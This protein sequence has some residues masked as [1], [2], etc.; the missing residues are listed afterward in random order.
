MIQRSIELYV[1]NVLLKTLRR[2]SELYLK[3]FHEKICLNS[4][5][6]RLV[7]EKNGIN[8][9]LRQKDATLVVVKL[10]ESAKPN[11]TRK[12]TS[13]LTNT[14]DFLFY[15]F[16]HRICEIRFVECQITNRSEAKWNFWLIWLF[17]ISLRKLERNWR[18]ALFDS[19]NLL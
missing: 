13:K 4:W 6:V 15:N 5:S 18:G 7:M 8:C 14:R 19:W 16:R 9:S 17:K 11:T 12:T 10:V 1:K 3:N 2:W